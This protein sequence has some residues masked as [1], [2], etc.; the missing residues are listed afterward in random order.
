MMKFAARDILRLKMGFLMNQFLFVRE[1]NMMK[2][3]AF[4]IVSLVLTASSAS[5]QVLRIQTF[6]ND[7]P[8]I[9]L[10]SE[11]LPGEWASQADGILNA[12]Q[13]IPLWNPG[14]WIEPIGTETPSNNRGPI[15]G[16]N[17]EGIP[18]TAVLTNLF[19]GVIIHDPFSWGDVSNATY[20][21]M[22]VK[23]S[24]AGSGGISVYVVG[25]GGTLWSWTAAVSNEAVGANPGDVT[26]WTN[27]LIPIK[28]PTSRKDAS[29]FPSVDGTEGHIDGALEE[30]GNWGVN[31]NQA[32][33]E[34][35]MEVWDSVMA[36]V[37]RIDVRGLTPDT[38]IDNLGFIL[39]SVG[40]AGDFDLDEDVD[41][42]DF[43]LWQRD[44][45][46]GNLADWQANFGTTAAVG[47]AAA[48]PEPSAI[49]LALLAGSM[50]LSRRRK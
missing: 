20:V 29:V 48:V 18:T 6:D 14:G 9:T 31:G 41:G 42:A 27:I 13:G 28:R 39:P 38:Q 32:S 25:D 23:G 45:S 21:T 11:L 43:L 12:S 35:M 16:A 24:F 4:L 10:V 2:T 34:A 37:R 8:D 36:T 3:S 44:M 46:V 7:E 19:T 47:A 22:D 1:I 5:A 50:L 33:D 26:E 49:A 15:G 30:G 40:T 17:Y